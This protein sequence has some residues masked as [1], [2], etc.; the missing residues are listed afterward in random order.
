MTEKTGQVVSDFEKLKQQAKETSMVAYMQDRGFKGR[1]SGNKW[2]CSSP[3]SRDTNWSFCVYPN[4]TFY[5]WSTGLNGDIFDL[6]MKIDGHSF[7]E[8]VEQISGKVYEEIK[9]P[10]YK[11]YK[12]DP[13]FNKEFEVTKYISWDE[14]ERKAIMEYANGR[15]IKDGYACGV[16]FT[17]T[18]TGKWQRN[19]AVLFAH[20]DVDGNPIGAK[21]R[22]IQVNGERDGSNKPRFSHRGQQGF[23]IL[24]NFVAGSFEEPTLYLVESES[25]ANSLWQYCKDIKK[26][27]VVVSFGGVSSV[28]K[29]LPRKYKDFNKIKIIIDY[30]GDEELYQKRI[31]QY[32]HL[33]G[34]PVKMQLPKG[35]DINSLY[36]SNKLN[37]IANLI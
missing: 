9:V 34:N 14:K 3:F 18:D 24:E 35:E 25:S 16:F 7:K 13:D 27:A 28:P 22:R 20:Y 12:N 17:R 10:N 31:A 5:D 30:D 33:K 32:S 4:N 26:N 36:C 8:A 19:P 29:E 11:K 15:G 37:L 23:Y 1:F 6:S 21:F 2:F